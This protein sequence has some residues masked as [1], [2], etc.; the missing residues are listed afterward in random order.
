MSGYHIHMFRHLVHTLVLT[1]LF[2]RARVQIP[3][4]CTYLRRIKPINRRD[5][6][7]LAAPRRTIGTRPLTESPLCSRRSNHEFL[8]EFYS[9]YPDEMYVPNVRI[10]VHGAI[11]HGNVGA[12][13][14]VFLLR[15][16]RMS[17]YESIHV[18]RL[19]T[20]HVQTMGK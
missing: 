20:P 4:L 8:I 1:L 18:F 6:T 17:E 10:N 2:E 19:V 13:S 12:L 7:D 5:R 14:T 15:M 9:F 11:N 3:S 16:Y